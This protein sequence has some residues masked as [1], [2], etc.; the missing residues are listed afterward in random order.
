MG[1]RKPISKKIRFEVF[2]RDKFTC[3]YC[4]KS[5]PDVVLEIDHIHPVSKDGKNDIMNL[6]TSCFDCNRGKGARTLDDDTVVKKQRDQLKELQERKEQLEMMLEWRNGLRNIQEDYVEAVA[7]SFMEYTGY[8][9]KDAGKDKVRK[10]LKEFTLDEILDGMD[11]AITAYFVGTDK[12]HKDAQYAFEK[13]SGICYI[14]KLKNQKDYDKRT[15]YFN[16]TKKAIL[17]K[18][19][20]CNP[21]IL[22]EFIFSNVQNDDDF[23]I[24]KRCLYSAS[25]WSNFCT[26][27]SEKF[28]DLM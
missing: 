4:G 24:V 26:I 1:K 28:D 3:Q 7:E 18:G 5:A 6:I 27:M 17:K 13:I 21:S 9:L 23:M 8:S 12:T 25:S 15:Y 14:T 22:H 20:Y 11:T 16:Y 19:W 2:K 10:W